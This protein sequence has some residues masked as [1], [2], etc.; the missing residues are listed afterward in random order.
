MSVLLLSPVIATVGLS[1]TI[2]IAILSDILYKHTIFS[3]I[4]ILGSLLVILGFI[5]VNIDEY[6]QKII[7]YSWKKIFRYH[8][9]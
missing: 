6:I 1:L 2:P 3:G 8:K 4:Y 9:S 5:I 7:I